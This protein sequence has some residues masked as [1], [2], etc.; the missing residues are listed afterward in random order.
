MAKKR[1]MKA[2][3]RIRLQLAWSAF[4]LKSTSVRW[5]PYAKQNTPR[6]P[7]YCCYP[8]WS[9][10]TSDLEDAKQYC[11]APVTECIGQSGV[12]LDVSEDSGDLEF[13]KA[14]QEL[15]KK[16]FSAESI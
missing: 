14:H 3:F 9:F 6:Q 12:K 8:K 13:C 11:G 5:G 10:A 7:A 15:V 4:R 1:R 2:P 16:D